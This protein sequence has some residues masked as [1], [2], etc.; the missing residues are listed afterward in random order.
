[1]ILIQSKSYFFS[2]LIQLIFLLKFTLITSDFRDINLEQPYNFKAILIKKGIVYIADDKTDNRILN[3]DS[4]S[5]E[6][7]SY[8]EIQEKKEITKIN[9]YN[10][11]ITGFGGE[12][13]KYTKINW[14]NSALAQSPVKP[15][16]AISSSSFEKYNF[17]CT[18]L[19]KCFFTSIDNNNNNLVIY[20]INLDSVAIEESLEIS[21]NFGNPNFFQCDFSSNGQNFFCIANWGSSPPFVNKY[22]YGNIENN[23]IPSATDFGNRYSFSGNIKKVDDNKYLICYEET[24][25]APSIK[26]QYYNIK[27]NI[28]YR[29]DSI[30]IDKLSTVNG[31]HTK[32]LILNIYKSSIFILNDYELINVYNPYSILILASIDLKLSINKNVATDNKPINSF[33]I[34]NDDNY[35]YYFYSK[36]TSDIINTKIERKSFLSSRAED[37]IKITKDNDNIEMDLFVGQQGKKIGFSLNGFKILKD[38]E[39]NLN[40]N[41]KN[42]EVI[43][44]GSSYTLKKNVDNGIFNSYYFFAKTS[45]SS[46]NIDSFS[47]ISHLKLIICHKACEDCNEDTSPTLSNQFCTECDLR[48]YFPIQS[49]KVNSPNGFNCYSSTD[50]KVSNYYLY[51]KKAFYPCHY[52]CKSCKNDYSCDFCIEGYYFKTNEDNEILFEEKC[53]DSIPDSYYLDFNANIAVPNGN[54]KAV[55]KPCYNTCKYCLGHGNY[56]SNSCTSCLGNYKSYTFNK[57]QCTTDYSECLQK[58]QYWKLENN[59]IICLD[60]C[61]NSFVISGPN[62]GQCVES[63]DNYI[64][65][66]SIEQTGHLLPYECNDINYCI[67]FSDCYKGSFYISDD[68]TRCERKK[69]CINVDIFDEDFDPFEE[70]KEEEYE[71]I[72]DYDE[73]IEDISKRLII[74][75]MFIEDKKDSRVLN[76]FYDLSIIKNYKDLLFKEISIDKVFNKYLITSTKY[77]NFTITIYPL[78][79]EDYVYNRVFVTNKLGFVN[80]TKMFPEF[81]NYELG[82]N[83]FILACILERHYENKSINELN[84]YLT[85]FNEKRA[86][87]LRYKGE[88]I[89]LNETKEFILNESSQIEIIYPLYNYVNKSSIANKRNTENLVDNIKDFNSRYPEVELYNL[90]D[91]FY[92]DICFLFTSDVGT[93]MTLND[94]RYEYYVNNSLCEENCTLIKI[95][96][97]DTEPK[98]VCNCDIKFNVSYNDQF[99]LNDDIISYSVLN[100]KSFTCISETFNLNL[101]KN[102]NFWIFIIILIL[103]VYLLIIY[104]KHSESIIN[105]MLG[106]NDNNEVVENISDESNMS[107]EYKID[108]IEKIVKIEKIEKKENSNNS[109]NKIESQKDEVISAPINISNPPRKIIDI[110]IQNNTTKTD[111]KVEEK[112]LISGNESSYINTIKINDKNQQEFTDISFDDLKEGYEHLKIDNLLEQ[113]GLM[114]RDNYLKY[115]ILEER[116]IKMKII[117]QSLMPLNQK[118]KIKYFNTCEDIFYNGKSKKITKMLDGKD[119]FQDYLIDNYSDNEDKPGYPKAKTKFDPDFKEEGLIGDELIFPGTKGNQPFLIEEGYNKKKNRISR[120]NNLDDLF[121]SENLNINNNTKNTYKYNYKD[122]NTLP[123]SFGKKDIYRLKDE[124]EKNEKNGRLKTEIEK[125]MSN[126]IKT[127]LQKISKEEKSPYLSDKILVKKRKKKDNDSV[128]SDINILIKSNNVQPLNLKKNRVNKINKENLKESDSNRKIGEEEIGSDMAKENPEEEYWRKKR[129]KNLELLKDKGFFSSMTEILETDNKEKLIEENIILYY[130]KYFI[131]RELWFLTIYNKKENIPY[132]VRYSNLALCISFIFLLN[133]FFFFQSDVHKRYMNALSG[134]KNNIGYYFKKEFPT[135]ICVSL[136]G[137]LFKMIMIKLVVYN[138]FKISQNSKRMMKSSAEKCLT[139]EEIDQ[140]KT[141]KEKYIHN[142]KRNLLIYF[143]CIMVFNVF[144]AYICICYAGVFINSQGALLFGLLFSLIFSFIFCAFFCLIIVC[145]Y[146]IGKFFNS[147]CVISAYIVLSTLY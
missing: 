28:P 116:R 48:D 87:I 46:S 39:D 58:N 77:D 84:Y 80:F 11:V 14:Q 3:Q 18:S 124:E 92:N 88:K 118:N 135:T 105:K 74:M 113:K 93:D 42:L 50:E 31:V 76:D 146:R 147:R 103:Q 120:N 52:S 79:I 130:W 16:G 125:N 75:K 73:K 29:E 19:E 33:Q 6:I 65:P 110:K 115:P 72:N 38:G 43:E 36:E 27:S 57:Q 1:M 82:K 128:A 12:I 44:Q 119:I 64:N 13:F 56:I 102:G 117:K 111:A 17:V 24:V 94:R 131:K 37:K 144:I 54:I 23:E 98:S 66:F 40:F 101:R 90:S 68:G 55:Y 139:P 138:I 109:K 132:I 63:C 86:N 10:F 122:N 99:G 145:L 126:K 59:N 134:N 35:Y 112:D 61:E 41:D 97:R 136:L 22:Y 142:Y 8:S 30:E 51:N 4:S 106:L 71:P 121:N 141:K 9:D 95:I 26:C 143:I 32:P 104:I 83:D 69:K 108:N 91:P 34:F 123:K 7:G 25:S 114:L 5:I 53:S 70:E 127:E 49:E 60:E 129:L 100:S 89:I 67:P 62:K 81:I 133:C 20:R 85:S 47:L 15:I 107:Y 78:D 96:D 45:G 21:Q 140:L 2:F 137:N